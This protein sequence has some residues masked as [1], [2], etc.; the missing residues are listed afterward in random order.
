[1][2]TRQRHI[3]SLTSERRW[4]CMP[5]DVL[6]EKQG[7]LANQQLTNDNETW[8]NIGGTQA[9]NDDTW[10]DDDVAHQRMRHIVQ[11]MT[12]CVVIYITRDGIIVTVSNQKK[13]DIAVSAYNMARSLTSIQA[14][15]LG[16]FQRYKKAVFALRDFWDLNPGHTY[17][18]AQ[19]L[20]QVS[21]ARGSCT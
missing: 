1:M 10:M 6:D 13:G 8:M 14:S 17:L 7:S 3:I 21:T 2:T 20:S 4:T 11:T 9:N 12:T 16:T 5:T 15:K 18:P 19:P